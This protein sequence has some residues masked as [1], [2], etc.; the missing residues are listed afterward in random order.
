MNKET[1]LENAQEFIEEYD[2]IKD[3]KQIQNRIRISH[4]QATVLQY[5]YQIKGVAGITEEKG[6]L[7]AQRTVHPGYSDGQED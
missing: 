6:G 3:G 1:I 4:Y 5:V 2:N 7:H